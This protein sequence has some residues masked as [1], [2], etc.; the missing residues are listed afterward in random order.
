MY[1]FFYDRQ[2]YRSLPKDEALAMRS[3]IADA[4]A[5]WIGR[6]AHF[7]AV[8]LLLEVGRQRVTA[9][10]ERC[11]QRVRPLKEPVLPVQA[12]ESTSSGSS[13]L[14]G[15]ISMLPEAQEGG[16]EQET[17]RTNVAR[18]CRCQVKTKPAP[19]GGGEE[20]G[21]HLPL[22]NSQEEQIQMT[23]L[24]PVSLVKVAGIGDAGEQRED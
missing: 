23:T 21:P 17:P 3:H 20:V 4:F 5:E 24:Q 19:G 14:V 9:M 11:R 7:E 2:G 13:Q 12:N 6:S 8:P 1:L 18:P 16:T 22:Q 15:G 10:Q